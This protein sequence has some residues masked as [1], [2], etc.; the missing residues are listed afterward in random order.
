MP[1]TESYRNDGVAF[2]EGNPLD[3]DTLE[4]HGAQL[5]R[6]VIVLADSRRADPDAKTALCVLALRGLCNDTRLPDGRRPLICA[7]AHNHQRIDAI[8]QAGADTV[9]CHEQYGLG[10]LAQCAL[11][12]DVR[13]VF[14]EL[15]TF[16]SESCEVYFLDETTGI[17]LRGC[18]GRTFGSIA[19]QFSVKR[20]VKNPLMLMG[21][22]RGG[23]LR[24]NPRAELTIEPGDS[25]VVLSWQ[26]P[27]QYDLDEALEEAPLVASRSA[28]A[29]GAMAG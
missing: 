16:G 19:A 29:A 3:R 28:R 20:S 7:E 17:D 27:R 11:G 15:L 8:R 26:R 24:L 2:V 23:T 12:N 25:L 14:Q 9:I 1:P 6:A 10:I 13:G 18:V 21:V 5:A 22:R 4:G